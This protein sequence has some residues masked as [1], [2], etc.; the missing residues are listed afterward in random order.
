[1]SQHIDALLRAV[2]AIELPAIPLSVEAATPEV[3]SLPDYKA[4]ISQVV[5][6]GSQ[7]A[8]FA[9]GVPVDLRADVANSFL[10]A[11]LAADKMI[12]AHPQSSG[13]TWYNGYV[14]TM[15]KCGWL[16]EGD[17]TALKTVDGTGAQVHEEIIKV[18]T[19]ALGPAVSAASLI[20]GVLNGLRAMSKDQPFLT[21]F[22]RASNRDETELFQI[23][24]VGVG[25]VAKEPRVKL[26]AYRLEA[27][28]SVTQI[29]FFKFH[30]AHA[31]LRSFSSDLSM[32]AAIFA[33]VR[34]PIFDKVKDRVVGNIAQIDI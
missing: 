34:K 15:R 33:E 12:E 6:V 32:D 30:S 14:A 18:L 1:M 3:P 24:Y 7:I 23:S 16:L 29:L 26:A 17:E 25:P 28:A 8:E 27:S 19:L 10:L 5:T 20:V 22:D 4:G 21:I 9:A 31:R 11:Q 2:E 13:K